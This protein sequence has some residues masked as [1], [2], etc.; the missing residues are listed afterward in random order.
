MWPEQCIFFCD[1]T[2]EWMPSLFEV[3]FFFIFNNVFIIKLR[4]DGCLC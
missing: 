1:V 2:H 4:R 3:L